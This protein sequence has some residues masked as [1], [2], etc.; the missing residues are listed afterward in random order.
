ME[1]IEAQIADWR[2]YVA[3]APGVNGRDVDELEDHLRHQI[4]ELGAAGL[5]P[6]EGF[7]I[8]VKRLGDVDALSR[9]FAREHSGRLWKQLLVGGDDEPA[10]SAGGWLEP[11]VFAAVAALAVQ[12]A[13]LA[14]D[15]PDEEP[16]WLFRNASLFVLP[17]L[18]AYFARRRRLDTRRCVLAAVPFALAALVVNLYPYDADSATEILV[19]L[20][21]PVVLWFAVA[22]PY[23]DGTL[24]A[25]E[26]RMDFVR[27]TGEWFIYYVLIAL[28]GGVLMG[29]TA[30]ILEPTGIDVERIAEWVVPSGAAAGVLVAAWLVEAKQR[31]V[32]N[33]APVL[34][35][36]FTPLFAVMLAGSAVV[37]AVTG[38]GEAFDR[39][40]LSVF[41]ALLVVV[42][43][44]VL[45]GM[46]ARDPG[47]D[48]NWMDR[49]QLVAVAGA[50]VL[51]VMVLGSMVARI[52]ELGF[53]PNRTAAL[54]L[55]LVLLVNLAGA[56]WLSGRF[57][58]GR[59]RLHRLERWQ[60]A[61]LP[62]FAL[63]AT[64]VVVL[65]PPLFGF[66]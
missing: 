42:L 39:E 43:A 52:G 6:D 32:E 33:M 30:A 66:G 18:A 35:M 1:S 62:L 20:H 47:T 48:P 9:E 2:A 29:L 46:S 41:D 14:G 16:N 12:V 19:G 24:R 64:T 8:A 38:L 59:S 61:Y 40:L 7:L 50:L 37:Y 17:V 22:Y 49:I 21:L 4:A 60:T 65:L 45:Y 34:T 26:R 44:L 58:T 23:M 3:G 15:F 55:N 54:G 25:H 13:R 63:W 56:A 31:V 28:G 57:L 51:D 5:T 36:L 53:S 11:V 27:F 10:R